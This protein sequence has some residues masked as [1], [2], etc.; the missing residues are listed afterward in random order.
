MDKSVF[1]LDSNSVI[2]HLN[3]K[4]DLAVVLAAYPG[5]EKHISVITGQRYRPIQSSMARLR[6][7]KANV[8]GIPQGSCVYFFRARSGRIF[9]CQA[10]KNRAFRSNSSQTAPRFA[11]VFPLQ[12]LAHSRQ[13]A[14]QIAPQPFL[15][16]ACGIP[17]HHKSG[18]RPAKVTR[19][20]RRK[21]W[22]RG[23]MFSP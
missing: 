11:P 13:F 5:C 7:Q 1:V 18:K 16:H 2:Y 14:S 21:T 3:K 4:L 19:G 22:G 17:P 8:T 10:R 6:S 15:P 20:V 23:P 9:A 12:S